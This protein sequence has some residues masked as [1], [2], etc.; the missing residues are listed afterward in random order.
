MNIIKQSDQRH[1]PRGVGR[2]SWPCLLAL[3]L[4]AGCSMA[5]RPARVQ[6]TAAAG[7][8]LSHGMLA[9]NHGEDPEA[10]ELFE[11]AVRLDP[12]QG[13]AYHWLG[14]AY[15]QLGRTREAIDQLQ[16][17]L[18]AEYPPAAGRERVLADLQAA[19]E[20]LE[21]A[22]ESP[23]V[24]IDPGHGPVVLGG[25][26][27]LPRWE[28][29][30]GLASAYD[31]NPGLLS[32]VLPFPAASGQEGEVP[33]DVSGLLDLRL[34][35]HPFYDRGGW[36]LGLS[37]EGNQSLYQ[38]LDELDLSFARGLVALAW[39]RSASGIVTGPLGY[40]R[41]PSGRGR[42]TVLLQGGGSFSWLDGRSYLRSAEGA[43]SVAI[44]VQR[45]GE[46]RIE[47]GARDLQFEDE[48]SL[49]LFQRSGSEVF[50]RL[51]QVFPLGR[52]GRYLRLDLATGENSAGQA[53]DTSFEEAKAE[54][55]A[56]LAGRWTLFLVGSLRE[57]SYG[58]PESNV[59]GFNGPPRDDSTWRI[60]AATVWRIDEHLSWTLR[61]S[62]ARR[63]S[64]VGF[65]GFGAGDSL[66]DYRRTV[67]SF[68]FDW[69]L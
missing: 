50:L 20:A 60:V 11:E 16:A 10:A 67:F 34:A 57:D 19:R 52:G 39:G 21:R 62:H 33:S 22:Q 58:H 36:S 56:P 66:L 26:E 43:L 8:A 49:P 59:T 28:G 53:F 32:E 41:V 61:G 68:G 14:L 45:L 3:L 40:S 17:S 6:S 44:P 12:R 31:S 63:D 18:K 35:A 48:T 2:G 27:E 55:S 7:T 69:E 37:F 5:G 38:D 1:Q 29:R 4:L 54:L 9:F 51:G 25:F 65:G 30:I 47:L 13:S 46:T 24:F 23:P 15:L 42:A 64:N